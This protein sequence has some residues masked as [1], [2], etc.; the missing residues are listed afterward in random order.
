[1]SQKRIRQFMSLVMVAVGAT[2]MLG[3]VP[4]A[5]ARR[6]GFGVGAIFRD[7]FDFGLQARWN[8]RGGE[9]FT[10][11]PQIGYFFDESVMDANIDLHFGLKGGA[12]EGINLYALAGLNWVTDFDFG[13]VGANLGGG[14][15]KDLNESLNGFA[16]LKYVVGD[17][18]GL[19]LT[20]G[21][22]F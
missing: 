20:L 5:S 16:E 18:D 9:R 1:M 3:W 12:D 22:H 10:V 8:R 11:V 4:E 15:N 21:V 6:T 14:L 17:A 13:E 7:N 2:L 19:A